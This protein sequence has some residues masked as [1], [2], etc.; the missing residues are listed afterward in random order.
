MKGKTNAKV[1]EWIKIA[2][3]AKKESEGKIAN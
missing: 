1:K 2:A 3:I